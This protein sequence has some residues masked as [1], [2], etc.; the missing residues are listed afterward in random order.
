MYRFWMFRASLAAT[1]LGVAACSEVPTKPAL[2]PRDEAGDGVALDL[3]VPVLGPQALMDHQVGEPQGEFGLEATAGP[4]RAGEDEL[5]SE[6]LENTF[7]A[8]YDQR[9][10]AG[11]SSGSAYA[12]GQH[13]YQGNKS[14][15]ETTVNVEYE[16]DFLGS[17]T[18]YREDSTPFV[19]D[20]G[21][22]KYLAATARVYTDHECGLGVWGTSN[23]S[24]WWEAVLGGG[25]SKFGLVARSSMS[26]RRQ[27][28]ACGVQPAT[29][30]GGGGSSEY[31]GPSGMTC[32]YSVWYNPSTGSVYNAELLYCSDWGD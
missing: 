21:S 12:V 16:N 18:A 20:F 31:S 19:L 24:A 30:W 13:D 1:C 23:H 11:F 5:T 22:M 17:Q 4:L 8:L 28:D 29:S 10:R 9:T 32:Y 3:A 2:E 26:D 14:R 6:D 7:A 27:Q 15:I 25:V